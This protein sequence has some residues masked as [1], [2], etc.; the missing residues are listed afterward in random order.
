MAREVPKKSRDELISDLGKVRL[1]IRPE[2]VYRHHTG[3]LYKVQGFSV[4][5]KTNEILVQYKDKSFGSWDITFSR[6]AKDFVEPR[7]TR[8]TKVETYMTREEEQEHNKHLYGE[9]S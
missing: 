3:K 9:L 6:P 2:G 8:V 1:D 7:F 4:D 5:C